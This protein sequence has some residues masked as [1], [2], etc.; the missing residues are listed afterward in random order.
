MSLE[1]SE[2]GRAQ[3]GDRP[4]LIARLREQLT[5]DEAALSPPAHPSSLFSHSVRVAHLALR[6]A[7]DEG[8]VDPETAY[9]GGLLHDAGKLA[10]GALHHQGL[11]E[12]EVSARVAGDLLAATGHGQELTARLQAA[13]LSLY[14]DEPPGDPLGAIVYDADNLDKLGWHGVANLF[15]KAGLRGRG[16]DQDMAVHLGV[17]LTYARY[18]ADVMLTRSGQQRAA[19]LAERTESFLTAMIDELRELGILDLEVDTIEFEGL[20]ITSVRPARCRCSGRIASTVAPRP[21]FKC[22]MLELHQTCQ[23]CGE[24]H[25]VQFCCPRLPRGTAAAAADSDS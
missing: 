22:R 11:R 6:L 14:R 23:A 3:A 7:E 18:A 16:L 25:R 1:S 9:L 13:V 8:S 19:I 5:A 15:I 17:E 10:G 24:E 21:A 20:E 2:P 4:A 12:E